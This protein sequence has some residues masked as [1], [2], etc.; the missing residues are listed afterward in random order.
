VRF[1]LVMLVAGSVLITGCGSVFVGFVSN[2][3]IPSSPSSVSGIVIVVHLGTANDSKGQPVTVTGV[4]FSNGGLSSRVD[5][6][7]DEQSQFRINQSV[8]ADFNPGS[9]CSNL[10]AV[11]V[12]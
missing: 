7:G 4:T 2:P 9:V 5:F 1:T 3:Q 11:V 8:R 10:I 6:C 12:L